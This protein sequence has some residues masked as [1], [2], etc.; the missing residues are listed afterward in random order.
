MSK[1]NMITNVIGA[2]IGICSMV[3]L[4]YSVGWLGLIGVF[5][6]VWS[7]NMGIAAK[8]NEKSQRETNSI[9]NLINRIFG[10]DIKAFEEEER[11]R[12][13]TRVSDK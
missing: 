5:L 2:L 12:H 4:Y 8:L 1:V 9:K 11:M 13:N 7:N 10:E 3:I 6:F